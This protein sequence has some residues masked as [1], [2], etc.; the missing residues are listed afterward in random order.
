MS[1]AESRERSRSSVV[2]FLGRPTN[3]VESEYSPLWQGSV[4]CGNRSNQASFGVYC[5]VLSLTGQDRT[6]MEK[7]IPTRTDRQCCG[8][9]HS[10][11]PVPH[12]LQEERGT[13]VTG[14]GEGDSSHSTTTTERSVCCCL[15]L[16]LFL[17]T[18]LLLM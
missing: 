10:T 16:L 14:V 5:T 3:T 6:S 13:C 7:E 8:C 18:A 1:T 11:R 9:H 17:T 2:A 12:Y 15:L 4:R